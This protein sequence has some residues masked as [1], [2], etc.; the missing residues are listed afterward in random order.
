MGHHCIRNWWLKNISY[1]IRRRVY[2]FTYQTSNFQFRFVGIAKNMTRTTAMLSYIQHTDDF[3]FPRIPSSCT[4]SGP[5]TPMFQT[6]CCWCRKLKGRDLG[7]LPMEE[8]IHKIRCQNRHL[9]QQFK[10]DSER[11]HGNRIN[12]RLSFK[13]SELL[14]FQWLYILK[15]LAG[16]C[17]GEGI[18]WNGVR[19]YSVTRA[20]PI[21]HTQNC[22]PK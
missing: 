1:R 16:F 10:R 15:L 7:W 18:K 4:T 6:P 21:H 14:E 11:Q 9:A 5:Y 20:P 3:Q 19:C 2:L 22:N 13:Q 12:L 17:T 8:S